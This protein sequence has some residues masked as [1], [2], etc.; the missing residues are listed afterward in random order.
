MSLKIKN[1][2]ENKVEPFWSTHHDMIVNYYIEIHIDI[3]S[4]DIYNFFNF[5]KCNLYDDIAS[6]FL[7][8]VKHDVILLDKNLY[9]L[10]NFKD[11]YEFQQNHIKN[12]LYKYPHLIK[13]VNKTKNHKYY[14][15]NLNVFSKYLYSCPTLQIH[16]RKFVNI[17]NIYIKYNLYINKIINIDYDFKYKLK[18]YR[19]E[20]SIISELNNE[21]EREKRINIFTIAELER[22]IKVLF[23]KLLIK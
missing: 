12:F 4:T 11:D 19:Y 13:E 9:K 2:I 7:D 1:M 10:L 21:S 5:F 22:K 15:M 18:K 17:K 3:L 20:I 23:N 6:M 16:Y 14:I 8:L